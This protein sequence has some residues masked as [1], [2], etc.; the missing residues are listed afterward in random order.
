MA[1]SKVVEKVDPSIKKAEDA[2]KKEAERLERIRKEQAAK[3]F[4]ENMMRMAIASN[5]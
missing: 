4:R 1:K 2:K 5:P 3:K